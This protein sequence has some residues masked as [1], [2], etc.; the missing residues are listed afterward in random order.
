MD[1]EKEAEEAE[2]AEDRVE[3]LKRSRSEQDLDLTEP[4]RRK[5]SG[6]EGY[7]KKFQGEHNKNPKEYFRIPVIGST[8]E[9][10]LNLGT[11][12]QKSNRD[13]FPEIKEMTRAIGQNRD[14]SQQIQNGAENLSRYPFVA[15]MKETQDMNIDYEGL[16]FE[17]YHFEGK[18]YTLSHFHRGNPQSSSKVIAYKKSDENY[19]LLLKA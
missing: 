12:I 6:P 11:C 3:P 14:I 5:C 13:L 8:L 2:E 4:K 1:V 17:V 19:E 16:N 15:F 18:C 10:V 9:N 7:L